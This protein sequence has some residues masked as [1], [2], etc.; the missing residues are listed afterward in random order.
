MIK[1]NSKKI[2]TIICNI[3]FF[4]YVLF[5]YMFVGQ[6]GKTLYYEIPMF[7]F[8]G[9]ELVLMIKEK[10]ILIQKNIVVL[11]L[12][13]AFL[14]VSNFWAIDK[15][16]SITISKTVL[17]L[18]TSTM[19]MYNYF[20]KLDNGISILI[21]IIIWA[22]I[23]FSIYFF[24]YYGIIN[25]INMIF[26]G[27]R[28]GD[29]I[30][31]VNRI[32]LEVAVTYLLILFEGINNKKKYLFLL[33]IPLIVALGTGSRKVFILLLLGTIL[34][35]LFNSENNKLKAIAKKIM[36]LIALVVIIKIAFN[37]FSD[38]SIIKRLN[39]FTNYYTGEG[40]V[41][42]STIERS[43]YIKYGLDEFNN[44]PILGIGAANSSIITSKVSGMF[45]YLHNN[46]VE[47]LA[48]TGIIGFALYYFNYYYLIKK[49][50]NKKCYEVK[51]KNIKNFMIILLLLLLI[52]DYGQ[53]SYYS[54]SLYVYFLIPMIGIGDGKNVEKN[55]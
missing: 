54:K 31:N 1:I 12:F 36:I 17:F 8:I 53:V 14:F 20:Y 44:H 30:D 22:G 19:I 40:K 47:L 49:A 9:I 33:P 42:H 3:L 29:E 26:S 55:R 16:A 15:N 34:L 6:S 27:M 13:S 37:T 51:E 28:V 46:Y 2:I 50:F 23:V 7:V 21:K 41:D 24:S 25:C 48:T 4:L 43:L 10:K 39:S 11:Y 38:F 18:V 32:G 52:L 45:T 5:T 35:V